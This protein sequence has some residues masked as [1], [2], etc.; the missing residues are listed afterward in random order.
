MQE[1]SAQ[2][3]KAMLEE[4][5][6]FCHCTVAHLLGFN[7]NTVRRVFRI[8]RRPV[9]KRPVGFRPRIKA[10]P[11]VAKAPDQRWAAVLCR[12]WTGGDGLPSLAQLIHSYSRELLGSYLM[13]QWAL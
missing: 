11:L 2:P 7:K 13:S 5:S 3:I 6:S 4:S 8:E 12:V 9:R 1:R 10:L